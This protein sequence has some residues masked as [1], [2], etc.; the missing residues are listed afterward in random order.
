MRCC[1][2]SIFSVAV[3]TRIEQRADVPHSRTVLLLPTYPRASRGLFGVGKWRVDR[4]RSPVHASPFSWAPH[5]DVWW[6]FCLGGFAGSWFHLGT[7]GGMLRFPK[8][9]CLALTPPPLGC[10]QAGP[11][12]L[13]V[14]WLIC[15]TPRRTAIPSSSKYLETISPPEGRGHF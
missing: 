7:A 15:L 3:G 8:L 11:P 5:R 9:W 2:D 14:K 13:T 10:R 6:Q 1:R 4:T 12:S